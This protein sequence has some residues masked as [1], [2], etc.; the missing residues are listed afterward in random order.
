MS[1]QRMRFIL[2]EYAQAQKP[3]ID[4]VAQHEVDE[5]VGAAERDGWL[6]PVRRE[7]KEAFALATCEHDP[8][9]VRLAPHTC[10]TTEPVGRE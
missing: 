6:R 7:W 1:V 4:Q 8:E 3:R 10:Q 2:S 9:Y 5:T